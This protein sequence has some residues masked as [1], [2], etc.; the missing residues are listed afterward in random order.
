MLARLSTDYP[1][2]FTHGTKRA[3]IPLKRGIYGDIRERYPEISARVVFAALYRYTRTR[4]YQSALTYSTNRYDLDG[5]IAGSVTPEDR[6][7]A[8]ENVKRSLIRRS[9]V[10]K[11]EKSEQ[12]E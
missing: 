10:A 9:K 4:K 12:G 6:A 7:K 5:N 11:I 3:R 1:D 8:K 2:L